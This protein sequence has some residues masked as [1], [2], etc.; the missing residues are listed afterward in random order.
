MRR[1]DGLSLRIRLP[2]ARPS[3][4]ASRDR[5]SRSRAAARR[6]GARLQPVGRLRDDLP[7]LS[8]DPL[9]QAG[10]CPPRPGNQ[11]PD[12]HGRRSVCGSCCN[13]R[14]RCPSRRLPRHVEGQPGAQGRPCAGS[15]VPPAG[16]PCRGSGAGGA[17]RDRSS[18]PRPHRRCCGALV[19][20]AHPGDEEV[21]VLADV[22]ERRSQASRAGSR[23]PTDRHLPTSDG[24]TSSKS[25]SSASVSSWPSRRAATLLRRSPPRPSRGD[26]S[27]SCPG[28]WACVHAPAIPPN[29]VIDGGGDRV[30]IRP[31]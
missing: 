30:R 15:P 16:P 11:H 8:L 29:R 14:S 3:R 2:A 24:F 28:L 22:D 17:A 10:E 21:L 9:A 1:V 5:G 20:D 26:R 6:R 4:P 13:L 18:R 31:R 27:W 19:P 7:P 12:T 23:P 25:A